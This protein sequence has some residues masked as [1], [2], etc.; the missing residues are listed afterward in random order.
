[1]VRRN[2]GEGSIHQLEGRRGYRAQVTLSGGKRV[3]KQFKTS[4]AAAAWIREASAKDSL[5]RFSAESDATLK[6]WMELFF[7]ERAETRRPSTITLETLHWKNHF[8]PIARVKLCDLDHL[9]IR[10]WLERLQRS[11]VTERRPDGQPHT[12]RVCYSLLRTALSQAVERDVLAVNPMNR[13]KRPSVPRPEPKY[14]RPEDLKR[15]LKH[16]A[17]T[18]DPRELAVQLMVR[19]GLRRGEALGLTW[20]DV[21]LET[22]RVSVTLQLQWVPD[23]KRPGYEH[24][25]R[26]PLKT[27]ASR[28]AV[29]A[30]GSLLD[31]LRE[32]DHAAQPKPGDFVVTLEGEP[33]DPQLMTRWLSNRSK[34]IGIPCSP[35]RLRHTAATLMLNEVGSIS[36]VSTFLGHTDLKTTSVYARVLNDTSEAAAAALSDVVDNL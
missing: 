9:V 15:V 24:L 6:E 26:V 10:R 22:G 14:L 32:L 8:G 31:R 36:T 12:V 13:V 27:Q 23:P 35:H 7:A 19:L 1:M 28:R 3:T 34:E 11:F 33:V 16:L 29:R 30:S 20:Q 25:A 5:R 17:A 21:D 2:K 18:G 4:S